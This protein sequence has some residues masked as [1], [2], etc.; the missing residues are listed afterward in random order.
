MSVTAERTIRKNR[1]HENHMDDPPQ[2][3]DDVLHKAARELRETFNRA[4]DDV[5]VGEPLVINS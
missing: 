3:L 5:E 2:V 4:C 1:P